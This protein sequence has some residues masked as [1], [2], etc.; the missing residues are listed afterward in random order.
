M[1][2]MTHLQSVCLAV[3]GSNL[4]LTEGRVLHDLFIQWFMDQIRARLL[5]NACDDQV[6][7]PCLK[8]LTQLVNVLLVLWAVVRVDSWCIILL[9][10][11]RFI[12][13]SETMGRCGYLE[14]HYFVVCRKVT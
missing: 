5:L 1:P 13:L 10:W 11:H 3:E 9:K 8:V 6:F 12:R 14:G 7:D 2:Q 4:L